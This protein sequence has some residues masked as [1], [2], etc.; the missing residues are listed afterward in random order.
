MR[1]P[2]LVEQT[3]ASV[4]GVRAESGH[5]LSDLLAEYVREKHLLLILDNCEHGME[6]AQLAD[7]LLHNVPG[8][9]ILATSR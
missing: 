4:L 8:L 7:L 3:V 2:A 1:D 5:S 6:P 9:K